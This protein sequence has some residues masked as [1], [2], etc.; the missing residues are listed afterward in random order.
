[1]RFFLGLLLVWCT[2]LL[3]SQSISVNEEPKVKKMME[4]FI[5]LNKSKPYLQGY[6]IQ[7]AATTSRDQLEKVKFEFEKL[8]PNVPTKWEHTN[9]Y[10]KFQ[11]GAYATKLE[12]LQAIYKLKEVYPGA[13][14]VIDKNIPPREILQS[15]DI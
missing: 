12:A 7:L 8:Y 9:P 4:H 13:Y 14:L 5:N 6:R 11:I 10:F 3:M 1:M 2:N 15:E